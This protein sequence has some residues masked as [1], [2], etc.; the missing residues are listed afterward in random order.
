MNPPKYVVN[1]GLHCSQKYLKYLIEKKLIGVSKTTHTR[2][3]SEYVV[4]G[5]VDTDLSSIGSFNS[6]VRKNK[7]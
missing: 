1:N 5:G 3:D 2:H 7:L 6:G 4:V